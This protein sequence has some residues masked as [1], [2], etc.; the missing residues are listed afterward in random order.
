[1][2]KITAREMA[3]IGQVSFKLFCQVLRDENFDWHR[4]NER[5]TVDVGSAEHRAMER[6][7]QKI[8]RITLMPLSLRAGR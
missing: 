6:V 5:W 4:F 2:A 7:L 3:Q 1:M 8:Y